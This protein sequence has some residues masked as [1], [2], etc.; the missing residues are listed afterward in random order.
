MAD[1]LRGETNEFRTPDEILG[2]VK[3]AEADASLLISQEPGTARGWLL[4]GRAYQRQ[5]RFRDALVDF[6]R[7]EALAGEATVVLLHRRIDTLVQMGDPESQRRL[8]DD[9]TKLLELDSGEFTRI[10]AADYCVHVAERL[11]DG[12]TEDGA[13]IAERWLAKA[14]DL[15]ALASQRSPRAMAGLGRIAELRGDLAQAE[16]LMVEAENHAQGEPAVLRAIASFFER[17]GR[18]ERARI[19]RSK[20]ERSD[21]LEVSTQRDADGQAAQTVPDLTATET[22]FRRTEEILGTIRRGL[23]ESSRPATRPATD[24]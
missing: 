11:P 20:A 1:T 3:Q 2:F 4:R 12:R 22:F 24:R 17:A 9:L 7:Y 18:N 23:G 21:P 14:S 8:L 5:R 13:P 15:Y 6:D 10:M 19:V 16:E